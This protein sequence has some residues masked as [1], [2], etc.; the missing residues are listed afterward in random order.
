MKVVCIIQARM[1][2]TRLPGKIFKKILGKPILWHVLTRAKKIKGVDEVVVATTDKGD[3]APIEKICN[4][5][6]VPI[7]KGSEPDVLE[8]YY[9]TAKKY[10]ADVVMR[11]TSDNPLLDPDVGSL[12][13]SAFFENKPDYMANNISQSYPHGLDMEIMRF[14]LLEEAY[15][16]AK[17]PFQREHV[18]PYIW[19]QPEKFKILDMP[20]DGSH[21]HLRVTIDEPDDF[22]VVKAVMEKKGIDARLEDIVA[23]AKEKPSPF[24]LNLSAMERHKNHIKK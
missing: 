23:L 3:E 16:N 10:K 18:T 20:C 17:E 8:R 4:E 9:Q 21:Y 12:L 5:L 24:E 11:L 19:S 2:S 13:V 15:R 6:A 1:A 22:E 7:F 14:A